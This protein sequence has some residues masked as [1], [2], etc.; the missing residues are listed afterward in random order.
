[1]VRWRGKHS[2]DA[3]ESSWADDV[4]CLVT[5]GTVIRGDSVARNVFGVVFGVGSVGLGIERVVS[6]MRG[7][8][9]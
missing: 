8:S 4:D 7:R 9:Q 3:Q 5:G 1:M 6:V 2:T